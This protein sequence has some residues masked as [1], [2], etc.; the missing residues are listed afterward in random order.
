MVS[1]VT[2]NMLDTESLRRY[3]LYREWAYQ[4]LEHPRTW[5]ALV[6][7]SLLYVQRGCFS[8]L[9]KL[10]LRSLLVVC[11]YVHVGRD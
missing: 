6:Y 3:V 4:T 10:L 11:W 1:R 7:H 8:R 9:G 2:R 5:K